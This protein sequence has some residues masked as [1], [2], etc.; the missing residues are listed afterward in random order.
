VNFAAV[1][2]AVALL[3]VEAGEE[4]NLYY[5]AVQSDNLGSEGKLIKIKIIV[6]YS[7]KR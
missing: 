2:V 1:V 6:Y 5:K 4:S 3:V 7:D